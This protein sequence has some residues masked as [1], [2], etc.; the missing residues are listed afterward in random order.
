MIL[1]QPSGAQASLPAIWLRHNCPCGDCRHANGQRLVDLLDIPADIAPRSARLDADGALEVVW[2][3]DGHVSRYDAAWLSAHSLASAARA[4]RRRRPVLWD[5]A[6]ADRIPRA[7]WPAM[8]AAPEAERR[9]LQ[10]LIDYGFLIISGVP[11]TSGAVVEVGD[12]IGHVRVT[13]YGRHFDVRSVPNPNNLAY[14]AVALGVH[15]DNPYRDPTPGLQL[16]HCLE[17]DAPGGDTILVDGFRAAELLREEDATAFSLLSWLPLDFRFADASAD[18]A[19]RVPVISTDFEGQVTAVHFNNRSMAPAD[20]PE[21]VVESWYDAYR[22]FAR[23]LRRPELELT[24]R[25]EP[26]D[27]MVM[28]N[29]RTLHGRTAFDV[30]AGRRHLQ[31]CYVDLDGVESRLRVLS[32]GGGRSRVIA[33]IEAMF[34]RRGHEGYGEGVS[35]REHAL[36]AAWIAEQ[37]GRPKA[38]VVAALLH[39]IGHLMHDLPEDIAD[40]GIDTQHES[41]ASAWLSQHFGP[42]VSE[43]VRLHVAAKRYLCHAEAG[44]LD[45]LSAASVLSLRLQGGPMTAE[46]AGRFRREPFLAEAVDL[47]RWDDEAKVV[48]AT[49]PDLAHFRPAIE[50]VLR[51]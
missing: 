48:G 10:A 41:L 25:L 12:R 35:Q 21:D 9:A 19:A 11:T 23:L 37:A 32:R 27:L 49:T 24:L 6:L 50:S 29:V 28:S 15:T 30:N 18:L 17:A 39:D 14:T 26:G 43:P 2:A 5:R 51:R 38:Q 47:R 42:E 7:D 8:L 45:R 4:A 40:Q 22:K 44:Y 36:Q 46:E 1:T 31:G 33:E 13:N 16:L 20:L 34:A 3:G